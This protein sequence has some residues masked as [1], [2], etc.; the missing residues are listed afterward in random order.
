MKRKIYAIYWILIVLLALVVVRPNLAAIHAQQSN[1]AGVVVRLS[2]GSL[3]THCI[4]FS[5]SGI[6]GY[7]LLMR[8][9]LNIVAAFDSGQGA[10][11]CSVA[12]T[13]CP[14]ESCLMCDAPNY[15][16]YWHLSNGDWVYAPAGSSNY[17]IHD[18]DVDGWSW[19]SGVS[20]SVVPFDQICAPPPT[21]TPIPPTD[22]PIPTDTPV[23]PTD[24]PIPPT[25]T[26]APSEPTSTPAPLTP[27][28]WFRLDDN[29]ITAGGCTNVR[30]D[31]THAQEIYL[32]GEIVGANGIQQVCPTTPQEHDLRVVNA[33]G[34]QTYTL[35]LGVTGDLPAETS[36]PQPVAA[37]SASPLP[38]VQPTA[39]ASPPDA[40][41]SLVPSPLPT[42]QP[43]TATPSCTPAGESALPAVA[44]HTP[45]LPTHT[46]S[47]VALAQPATVEQ[48][49]VSSEQEPSPSDKDSVS[50][51]GPIGYIVFAIIAGGLMGWLAFVFQHRK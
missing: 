3:T 41:P 32:N 38:T 47:A 45:D 20:P 14:V 34:E 16:S 28:A 29:P 27:Q 12:G 24:T 37:L 25:D 9:G 1:R 7:D 10:A 42:V 22:T 39:T 33:A 2:D 26:L 5:E 50:V 49:P 4:E 30:W 23:P 18:G 48:E 13:G 17:T 36:T 6:S 21:D 15:W 35:V 8:S 44:S 31:A 46:P 51:M 40:A 11:V 19:G 43:A